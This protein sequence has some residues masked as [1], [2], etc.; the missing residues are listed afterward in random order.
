MPANVVGE[1][2]AQ[3][4]DVAAGVSGR[5]AYAAVRGLPLKLHKRPADVLPCL[6]RLAHQ[7][8]CW[9]EG[10]SVPLQLLLAV[11]PTSTPGLSIVL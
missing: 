8:L 10:Q 3:V 5:V 6:H 4:D 1:L 7:L 2:T 9:R 11:I